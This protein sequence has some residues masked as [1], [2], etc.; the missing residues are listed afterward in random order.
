[1]NN[2]LTSENP[3]PHPKVAYEGACAGFGAYGAGGWDLRWKY[4]EPAS[5]S[6]GQTGQRSLAGTPAVGGEEEGRG[7]GNKK[8]AESSHGLRKA[9][10]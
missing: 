9:S 3:T 7:G 8:K 5:R 10:N 4:S 6:E 2:S 1:M